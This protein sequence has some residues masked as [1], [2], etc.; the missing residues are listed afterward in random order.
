MTIDEY[1]Q[2]SAHMKLQCKSGLYRRT[3]AAISKTSYNHQGEMIFSGRNL[4]IDLEV[5]GMDQDSISILGSHLK[6]VLKKVPDHLCLAHPQAT[7]VIEELQQN[8]FEHLALEGAYPLNIAQYVA[9]MSF[10]ALKAMEI[11]TDHIQSYEVH[12]KPNSPSPWTSFAVDQNGIALAPTKRITQPPNGHYTSERIDQSTN[13]YASHRLPGVDKC[14]NFHGHEY[15][16]SLSLSGKHESELRLL[17]LS[18]IT[19]I[20]QNIQSEFENTLFIDRQDTQLMDF[21][22]KLRAKHYEL[23]HAS[24]AEALCEHTTTKVVEQLGQVIDLS[25]IQIRGELAET[26]RQGG[27]TKAK[28]VE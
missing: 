11:P 28:L 25:G 5:I 13:W 8:N 14:K 3:D 7:N 21:A 22:K 15:K 17:T 1:N 12:I 20:L 27:V 24:T 19:N 10:H 4:K 23:D 16:F 18:H 6:E 2:Y 9:K 26:D